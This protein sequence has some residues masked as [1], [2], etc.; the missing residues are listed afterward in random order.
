MSRNLG[1]LQ[2][3]LQAQLTTIRLYPRLLKNLHWIF[4]ES[5]FFEDTLV[6]IKGVEL[7]DFKYFKKDELAMISLILN[8]RIVPKLSAI[9]FINCKFNVEIMEWFS[10]LIDKIGMADNICHQSRSQQSSDGSEMATKKSKKRAANET[11]MK[12]NANKEEGDE[13][14]IPWKKQKVEE[15]RDISLDEAICFDHFYSSYLEESNQ[16]VSDTSTDST[17]LYGESLTI[18]SLTKL[19]FLN[20]HFDQEAVNELCGMVQKM[21]LLKSFTFCPEWKHSLKCADK[22]LP[23]ILEQSHFKESSLVFASSG[24][25]EIKIENCPLGYNSQKLLLWHPHG[26]CTVQYGV[27]V[28]NPKHLKMADCNLKTFRVACT[29]TEIED[30][31]Y[32]RRDVLLK[33]FSHTDKCDTNIWSFDPLLN[34]TCNWL[35][36][37]SLDLSEN[38]LQTKG[39]R[40]LAKALESTPVI[41]SI[42]LSDCAIDTLGCQFIFNLAVGKFSFPCTSSFI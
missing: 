23:S 34:C 15:N 35:N 17:E 6:N 32:N 19:S 4:S 9:T 27:C 29:C 7:R 11:L 22:I 36:L 12:I 31:K 33:E 16:S 24:I 37:I 25:E 18:S 8:K 30:F 26:E 2:K 13:T 5:S 28:P 10:Q 14:G 3:L 20:C 42:K 40:S 1:R 39:A 21:P 41:Q 38:M